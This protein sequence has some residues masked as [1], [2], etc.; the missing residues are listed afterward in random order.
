MPSRVRRVA[1]HV[2]AINYFNSL[3]SYHNLVSGGTKD[4]LQHREW[5]KERAAVGN[6]W[7]NCLWQA[8]QQV[9]KLH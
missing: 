6:I 3:T 5:L 7:E 4:T 9:T 1:V 2:P 8:Q